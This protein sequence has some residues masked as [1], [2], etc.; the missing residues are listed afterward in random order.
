MGCHWPKSSKASWFSNLPITKLEPLVSIQMCF[1]KSKYWRNRALVKV[2]LSQEKA[3]LALAVKK[4]NSGLADFWVFNN[5]N[6]LVFDDLAFD[7]F[8]SNLSPTLIVIEF[9]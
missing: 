9:D 1:S 8:L 7:N 4:P 2:C 5:F 6:N 3:F